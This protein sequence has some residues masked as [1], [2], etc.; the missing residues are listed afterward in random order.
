MSVIWVVA[1]LNRGRDL[2]V[3]RIGMDAEVMADG[4]QI[5][6]SFASLRMT[7]RLTRDDKTGKVSRF[8]LRR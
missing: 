8:T 7:I 5:Q 4:G 1:V 3:P 2:G 6:R